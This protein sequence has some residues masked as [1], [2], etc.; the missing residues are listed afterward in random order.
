MQYYNFSYVSILYNDNTYGETN[1]RYFHQEAKKRGM[2]IGVSERLTYDRESYDIIA[3]KIIKNKEARVVV[4]FPG[5]GTKL[6]YLFD[7]IKEKDISRYFI[8]LSVYV[9]TSDKEI[10]GGYEDIANGFI[11]IRHSG[12]TPYDKFVEYYKYLTPSNVTGNPWFK[13]LWENY[14]GCQWGN[15]E[16]NCADY[17]DQPNSDY[18]VTSN[19]INQYYDAVYVY[20]Y[21]LNMLIKTNCP[22]AFK[23]QSL[24]EECV[25]GEKLLSYM[26]DV[27]FEGKVGQIKFNSDGDLLADY[28]FFQY[29]NNKNEHARNIIG[30]WDKSTEYLELFEENI[31]WDM[32]NKD[33]DYI[34]PIEGIPESLCSKPCANKQFPVQ[35]EVPCCWICRECRNNEIIVNASVCEVCPETTWTDDENATECIPIGPTYMTPDDII[36]S[37]LT[38]LNGLFILIALTF[39]IT[40]LINKDK[41]LVKASGKQFMGII[42]L[43][44]I[45]AYIVVFVFILKPSTEFCYVTHFGFNLTITLIYA[46]LLVKTTRVYRIFAASEN[47]DREL[48]CVSLSSQLVITW[49]L[50]SLQVGATMVLGG[51][52]FFHWFK[53]WTRIFP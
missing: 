9:W 31:H 17:A 29:M 8:W 52:S 2:C 43:G 15:P 23:D 20:A 25:K 16:N 18:P 4:I 13:P 7:M 51:T 45:L 28:T 26:K 22:E 10:E 1:A 21:A 44:A 12:R 40:F 24:L 53:G 50:C 27:S 36:A 48:R 33:I 35:Q 37:N 47:F 39:V 19:A 3:R 46:P 38:A 32:L 14:Y 34:E 41:K 42:M 49:I 5:G 11:Y 6:F 30:T